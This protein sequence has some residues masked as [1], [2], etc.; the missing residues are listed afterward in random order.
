MLVEVKRT[1]L[2]TLIKSFMW[3]KVDAIKLFFVTDAVAE[4]VR[5]F[6]PGKLFQASPIFV[7]KATY[8]VRGPTLTPKYYTAWKKLARD[9]HSSLFYRGIQ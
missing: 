1:N 3:P 6:I 5:V 8:N 9:K 7:I 2:F 4:S